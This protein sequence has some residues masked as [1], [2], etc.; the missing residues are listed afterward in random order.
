ML[1]L[2]CAV[3]L[4]LKAAELAGLTQN[5]ISVNGANHSYFY[6]VST[7]ANSFN[8]QWVVFALHDNGQSAP[9]FAEQS[10]WIK[11]AEENG[12]AVVFPQAVNNTW[13][14]VSGAEDAY[15][16]AVFD[17]AR[18]NLISRFPGDNRATT[19][20]DADN[21]PV[22]NPIWAWEPLRDLTGSGAGAT[23][24]QEFAMNNPGLF[25]AVATLN[26][27]AFD[28]AYAKG[29][30]PAQAYFQSMRGKNV[31]P[32]WKQMK[33]D[34]PVA[35]WLFNSGAPSPAQ[36]K[37]AAYWK[38][39]AAAGARPERAVQRTIGGFETTIY[40]N[41][42][43]P[44]QQFRTT[45]LGSN[46]RYD[47]SMASAIW[48]DLFA[49]VA[50]W[51]SSPNGDLTTVLTEAEVNQQFEIRTIDVGDGNPYQY[52]LKLPSS[53]KKGQQLP[54][55]ISTH[56]SNEQAWLFLSK[57]K[58]HELG[59]QEVFITAYPNG[60]QNHWDDGHPDGNDAKF[61]AL[62]IRDIVST[63]GAD[64]SR[65][66]MQGFSNGSAMTHMMGL[67]HPELFAA[68]SPDSNNADGPLSPEI[69]SR[70]EALKARYDYRVP[71][72]YMHGNVDTQASVDGLLP[73]ASKIR[74]RM[75]IW[76]QINHISTADEIKTFDSTN[77]LPY[78][79]VIPKGKLLR[80][81][82]DTR[83]PQG[84]FQTWQYWSNDAQPLNLYDFTWI[85][86]LP[87]AYDLRQSRLIWDYF[88]H[89]Q[90]KPDGSL[91]YSPNHS[92]NDSPSHSREI[93]K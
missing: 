3:P 57:I 63:Y 38:H 2:F 13:T 59:E 53:Y 27:V 81:G 72:F 29:K 82:I 68:V 41:A 12:F 79:Y 52:Y 21:K 78:V 90:R 76:K 17:H 56:G 54:L 31:P 87:H 10:G 66:Y 64:A 49:H 4:R 62:M 60:H 8:G 9:Q 15:L 89:W 43:N 74:N 75:D 28:A 30:E 61:L 58:M 80:S 48:N 86:D 85:L 44:A 6:Y 46:A 33:G 32:V 45:A 34:V 22:N 20:N 70:I 77:T 50:R 65:V 18:T 67:T 73:A 91:S 35:V 39:S 93:K 47:E 16:K 71:V 7:K 24:A 92:P 83:Y 84:R 14:P 51:T 23:V 26:G 1:A 69:L 40:Q 37:Q 88:K 36:A 5:T 11:L 19:P 55:V 25:A 42:A